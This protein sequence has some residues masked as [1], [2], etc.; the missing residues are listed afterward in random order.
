MFDFPADP[1]L[2]DRGGAAA[3]ILSRTVASRIN[4]LASRSGAEKALIFDASSSL[5]LSSSAPTSVSS[6]ASSLSSSSACSSLSSAASSGYGDIQLSADEHY[7]PTLLRKAKR[8]LWVEQ[9]ILDVLQDAHL[10]AV[11]LFA[12]KHQI[13]DLLLKL[14]EDPVPRLTVGDVNLKTLLNQPP[15]NL[16]SKGGCPMFNKLIMSPVFVGHK[17]K[18]LESKFM[19]RK[20]A[21]DTNGK[22]IPGKFQ[23]VPCQPGT[24][25]NKISEFEHYMQSEICPTFKAKDAVYCSHGGAINALNARVASWRRDPVLQSQKYVHPFCPLQLPMHIH[26]VHFFSI[27]WSHYLCAINLS[28]VPRKLRQPSFSR[29]ST[30]TGAVLEGHGAISWKDNAWSFWI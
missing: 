2:L 16:S 1:P 15:F 19:Y 5:S 10:P 17:E 23:M 8:C 24:I 6:A 18:N 25:F 28:I 9:S 4:S 27:L 12:E 7:N 20:Q 30:G 26:D 14:A 29:R 22:A 21:F 11:R 3:P 13:G